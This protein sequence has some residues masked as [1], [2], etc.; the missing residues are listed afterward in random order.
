MVGLIDMVQKDL[1]DSGADTET[2]KLW[3][4][5]TEWYEEGGP[6]VVE[7]GIMKIVREIKTIARKQ[8]KET[9]EV[10]PLRKKKKKTRR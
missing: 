1:K 3:K 4:S 8:L 9:K 5:I 2:L 10:M 7:E 6:D